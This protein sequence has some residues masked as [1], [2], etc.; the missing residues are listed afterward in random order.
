MSFAAVFL[1]SPELCRLLCCFPL[2]P[3]EVK[4]SNRKHHRLLTMYY[5]M[6][7]TT[8]KGLMQRQISE[9]RCLAVKGHASGT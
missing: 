2:Q 4:F 8:K 7:Y 3:H 9:S 1:A 5:I 6:C